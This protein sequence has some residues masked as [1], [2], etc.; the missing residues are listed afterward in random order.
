MEEHTSFSAG[1][2]QKYFFKKWF[3]LGSQMW[4][5][6]TMS[7]RENKISRLQRGALPFSPA[8][9]H[10]WAKQAGEAEL[11]RHMRNGLLLSHFRINLPKCFQQSHTHS[12]LSV[13]LGLKRQSPLDIP[14][15]IAETAPQE[16]HKQPRIILRLS[17]SSP[18]CLRS[19]SLDSWL[20]KNVVKLFF[21][22]HFVF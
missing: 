9:L 13:G 16:T 14:V 4:A 7:W 1:L 10:A 3:K 8:L 2:C 21:F 22:C 15:I 17:F 12:A 19:S 20:R 5:D 11:L 6:D 18:P